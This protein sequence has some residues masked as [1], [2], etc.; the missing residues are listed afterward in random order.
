MKRLLVLLSLFLFFKL[1]SQQIIPLNEKAYI[2]SLQTITKGHLPDASKATASLLLSNYYRNSDSVL[3]KKY[4]ANGKLLAQ[5]NPFISA[6][7]YYYEGQYN[8]D[9]N[10]KKAAVSYQQAIRSLSKF[11]NEESDFLQALAWY[12]YGVSQKDKEG[13]ITM[14]KMML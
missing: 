1:Q 9:R 5:S 14:V 6:K 2:D 3:S 8:L 7:Y 10:K 11:K 13:Y 12:S 4:L